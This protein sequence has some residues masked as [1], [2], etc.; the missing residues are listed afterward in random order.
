MH[1]PNQLAC[2]IQE[3]LLVIVVGFGGDL[4]V[5]QVLFP[6]EGDLLGF[7]LPVL[8]VHLV[9]AQHNRNVFTYPA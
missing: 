9:T 8:H 6:V 3:G 1:S 2:Q 4:I 5:L 7:D